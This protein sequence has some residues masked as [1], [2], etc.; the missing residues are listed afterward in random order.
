MLPATQKD[1]A[2]PCFNSKAMG[3]LNNSKPLSPVNREEVSNF[4]MKDD[5]SMTNNST[6][7]FSNLQSKR[8]SLKEF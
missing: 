8:Q 6:I 2:T 3:T 1:Y 7:N 4:S 5:F